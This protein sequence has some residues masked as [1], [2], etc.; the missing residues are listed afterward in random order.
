M[1]SNA[2]FFGANNAYLN[3]QIIAIMIIH[4]IMI[5]IMTFVFSKYPIFDWQYYSSDTRV[6]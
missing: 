4:V 2:I 6:I 5:M 3:Q 1:L